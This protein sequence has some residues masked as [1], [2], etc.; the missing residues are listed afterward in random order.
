MKH[1]F[2][3]LS[4]LSIISCSNNQVEVLNEQGGVIEKFQI[5]EDST[6][7]GS[8]EA[9]YDD[10]K[11]REKSNYSNGKYSGKRT[12]YYSNGNIEIEEVYVD[13]QLE[14]PFT[15]YW[16]NG[17]INIETH[18]KKGQMNGSLKRYYKTGSIQEEMVMENGFENGP[19][20]EYFANG[21]VE[22]EGSYVKGDN[23]NGPLV[24][25]DEDG[26]VLKKMNCVAGLCKTVWTKKDGDLAPVN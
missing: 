24:Q 13:D 21:Q 2:I 18:Y 23:E 11:L 5:L 26:T 14:G 10:G 9:F 6:K 20:K 8:Y 19:F 17:K 25:Y 1:I 3:L 4:A 15:A 12:I 16:D 7:H 22:W